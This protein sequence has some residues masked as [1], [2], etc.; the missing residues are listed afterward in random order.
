MRYTADMEIDRL[1]TPPEAARIL[2]IRRS[3]V[4]HVADAGKLVRHKI[5]ERVFFE[6]TA[7]EALATVPRRPGRPRKAPEGASDA[8]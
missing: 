3:S 2:G 6:R 4:Y 5:G 8:P 1:V 7:V